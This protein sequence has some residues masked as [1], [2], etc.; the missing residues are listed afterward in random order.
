MSV[1]WKF[2]IQAFLYPYPLDFAI[3][4]GDQE[5]R[6]RNYLEILG[7]DQNIPDWLQNAHNMAFGVDVPAFVRKKEFEELLP[8]RTHSLPTLFLVQERK[9][10]AKLILTQLNKLSKKLWKR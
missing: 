9:F 1:D 2:K 10:H 7:L 4:P 3:N 5:E 8:E 6:A